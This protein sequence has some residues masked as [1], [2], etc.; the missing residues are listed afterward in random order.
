MFFNFLLCNYVEDT[1][2]LF[3]L[4]QF[5]YEQNI[6]RDHE[7]LVTF[8]HS[9]KKY[10]A[11]LLVSFTLISVILQYRSVTNVEIS[12]FCTANYYPAFCEE[13]L[14]RDQSLY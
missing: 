5:F 2:E 6:G 7:N 12:I 10:F 11:P 14:V 13:F 3:V 8:H 9:I 4:H 1:V